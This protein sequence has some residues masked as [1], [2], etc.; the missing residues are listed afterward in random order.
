MRRAVARGRVFPQSYSIDRRYGRLSLKAGFLFPM[1]WANADDQGRLCG[2]PE[3]IKY[4]V[5]PNIDHIA[6]V[7]I[8]EILD[9]LQHNGLI[10]VYETPKSTAIQLLDWWEV[11]RPQWAYPSESPPPEGW[12]DRLR[13]HPTP[14]EIVTENWVPPSQFDR[15]LPS[16]LPNTTNKGLGRKLRSQDKTL[17]HTPSTETGKGNTKKNTEYGIRKVRSKLRSPLPTPAENELLEFLSSLKNWKF[18]KAD[19][20]SWLREFRQDWP[21][22]D[23]SLAKACRDFHSG[24]APPKHKG[25]WKTRLRHWMEIER[26]RQ[27]ERHDRHGEHKQHTKPDTKPYEWEEAP[28][29][30]DD[31]S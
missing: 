19:D 14:K 26:K 6:K 31:T 5:C 24:R 1:M 4:A 28:V 22:F 27:E 30:P 9:E 17:P 2:D 7:D 18:D 11:Q 8:P 23:M 25:I 21:D 3:E 16:A 15:E 13:Y 20:L 12:K 10:K 29:E